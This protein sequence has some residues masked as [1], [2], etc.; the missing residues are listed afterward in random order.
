MQP[1]NRNKCGQNLGQ[2][3]YPVRNLWTQPTMAKGPLIRKL[4]G[5]GSAVKSISCEISNFHRSLVEEFSERLTSVVG[6]QY[7]AFLPATGT[8]RMLKSNVDL[9]VSR[10]GTQKYVSSTKEWVNFG[11]FVMEIMLQPHNYNLERTLFIAMALFRVRVEA[12]QTRGFS[13]S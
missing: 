1:G 10:F 4:L 7:G 3:N 11:L 9:H 2:K 8:Q 13:F 6:V 5:N 12:A